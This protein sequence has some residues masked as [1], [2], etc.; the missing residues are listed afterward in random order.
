[1]P[2]LFESNFNG[3]GEGTSPP[4]KF[5]NSVAS[6]MDIFEVDDA[7][8]HSSPH[9]AKMVGTNKYCHS[10]YS[11]TATTERFSTWLY[12]DTTNNSR[13]LYTQRT[14]GDFD[15]T[16]WLIYINFDASANI[17]YYS[18]GWHDTGTNYSTG[19]HHIE[20]VH[21]FGSDVYDMWY[22]DSKIISG[23]GFYAA[24]VADSFKSFGHNVGTGNLW[25]DDVQIGEASGWDGNYNG[26]E[27]PNQLNDYSRINT[28]EVNG[29]ES[30]S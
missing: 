9:G 26:F 18:G 12:F 21:D 30:V 19:W 27:N 10:T 20:I 7:H 8:Y 13:A 4:V 3:E 11:F 29:Y 6:P 25:M 22:D 2:I 1:M 15:P 16:K 24:G 23:G 17:Q 5:L 14:P 28:R